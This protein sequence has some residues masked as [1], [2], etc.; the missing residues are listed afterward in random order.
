MIGRD[1]AGRPGNW[2]PKPVTVRETA[3]DTW[4]TLRDRAAEIFEPVFAFVSRIVR[5]A[6]WVLERVAV[7]YP[8]RW[9]QW[10]TASDERTCPECGALQGRT[11]HEQEAIPAPPLHVNCRCRVAHIRTEWRVRYTPVWRLRWFTRQLWE[12]TQTGWA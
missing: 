9:Y 3:A 1:A 8:V 10:Q 2:T 12:W 5:T 11:W 7:L 4:N 6:R